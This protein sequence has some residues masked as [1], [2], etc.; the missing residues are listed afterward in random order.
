MRVLGERDLLNL[1]LKQIVLH[2]T[3]I[4]ND[5]QMKTQLLLSTT[6]TNIV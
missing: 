6:K 5:G 4:V 2:H 3:K 1:L